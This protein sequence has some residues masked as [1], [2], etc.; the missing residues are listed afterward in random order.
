MNN[1]E[2]IHKYRHL[3]DEGKAEELVCR[4]G[5]VQTVGLDPND[6]PMLRCLSCRTNVTPGI[7]FWDHLWA[8]ILG[9]MNEND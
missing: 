5:A 4:C 8:I 2:I 3:V 7:D 1:W 6:E 9:D